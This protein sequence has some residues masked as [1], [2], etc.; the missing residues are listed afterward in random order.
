MFYCNYLYKICDY[1]KLM[2]LFGRLRGLFR[3]RESYEIDDAHKAYFK[4]K[5]P[6]SKGGYPG[7]DWLLANGLYKIFCLFNDESFSP[8]ELLDRLK[9]E[10]DSGGVNPKKLEFRVIYSNSLRML[11]EAGLIGWH[12]GRYSLCPLEN[13]VGNNGGGA[14]DTKT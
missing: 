10:R 8:A 7:V 13:E 4:R 11:E 9:K 12:H 3:L 6:L 2:G 14:E 1:F 5:L